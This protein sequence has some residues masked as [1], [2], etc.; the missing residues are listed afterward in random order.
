MQQFQKHSRLNFTDDFKR[1]M[2][3]LYKQGKKRTELVREYDLTPST[4]DN[5]I[6]Q[7][8]K[9]GSFKTADNRS[10]EENELIAFRKELKQLRMENDILKQAE[11]IMARK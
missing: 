6:Q 1:Q 4:L 9:S 10:V 5:W 3:L 11:L 8:Q 2:V 7:Y